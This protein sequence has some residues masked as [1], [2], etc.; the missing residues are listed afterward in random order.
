MG[1]P[2]GKPGDSEFQHD[3][4]KA[5]FDLM[6]AEEGPVLRDY[7]ETIEDASA[8]PLSCKIPPRED[9]GGH[10]AIDEALGLKP[11]YERSL[12]DSGRTNVGRMV[13]GA[14]GIPGLLEC[15]VKVADGTS[16]KEAGFPNKNLLE[17]SKD[18]MSYYEEAAVELAGH[19]PE[20]RA[21]ETWFFTQ[22]AAG[23]LLKDV[24]KKLMD[25]G[26]GLGFYVVPMT[27]Q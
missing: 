11:A 7:P 18:I 21:A 16:W 1:R 3:V 8:A 20:A 27:Q 6:D 26:V 13:D 15:F 4:L 25:D 9:S 14:D 17:A 19:V 24:R 22:T 23:Q 10:E 2:L 5:V 12:A